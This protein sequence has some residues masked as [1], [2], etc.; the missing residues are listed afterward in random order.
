MEL[1]DLKMC[2][3]IAREHNLIMVVDNTFC[4]PYLQRP[5]E[6]GAH[7]VLHSMTKYIN[8]HAD[9]VGSII[10]TKDE[11]IDKKI[12]TMMINMG[13]CIDLSGNILC[14]EV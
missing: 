11:E 3:E 8:G 6:F 10:I 1:T 13:G 5:L 7:V 14:S 4:S 9:I 12:R 2:A